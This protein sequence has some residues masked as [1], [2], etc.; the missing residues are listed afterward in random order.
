MGWWLRKTQATR[1]STPGWLPQQCSNPWLV[2][3]LF[4][5]CT[6]RGDISGI[7]LWNWWFQ[8]MGLPPNHPFSIWIWFTIWNHL[9]WGTPIY[10]NSQIYPTDPRTFWSIWVL[11]YCM[12][13]KTFSSSTWIH[14]G[15]ATICYLERLAYSLVMSNMESHIFLY[16]KNKDYTVPNHT[17]FYGWVFIR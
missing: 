11:T 1:Y 8:K 4:G 16:V 10:G 2:D 13:S 7:L 5:D 14:G 9:C 12:A 6:T 15:C 17:I 3:E